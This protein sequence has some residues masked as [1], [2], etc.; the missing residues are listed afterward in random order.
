MGVGVGEEE[1]ESMEI[2]LTHAYDTAARSRV[3]FCRSW[4]VGKGQTRGLCIR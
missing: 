3:Q 2:P 1:E 4:Q